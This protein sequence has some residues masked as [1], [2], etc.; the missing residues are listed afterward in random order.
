M[1]LYKYLF[2]KFYSFSKSFGSVGVA[3]E[4]NAWFN[5]TLFLYLNFISIKFLIEIIAK[6]IVFYS[7]TDLILPVLIGFF[8]Y[9]NSVRK[10][11]YLIYENLFA[12]KNKSS[13][14]SILIACYCIISIAAF[15]YLDSLHRII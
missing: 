11:N 1:K 4:A 7:L 5:T 3:N 12:K 9:Y 8:V 10:N 2:F 6:K 13:L 15:F 14:G